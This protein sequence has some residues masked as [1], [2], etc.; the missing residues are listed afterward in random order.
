MAIQFSA[1]DYVVNELM[2]VRVSGEGK[3]GNV[4]SKL[5]HACE[6]NSQCSGE[7][8]GNIQLKCLANSV[9]LN[10]SANASPKGGIEGER[11]LAWFSSSAPMRSI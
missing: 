3:V 4:R 2:V 11:N 1:F 6:L 10:T 5:E 7:T 8:Y 9:H